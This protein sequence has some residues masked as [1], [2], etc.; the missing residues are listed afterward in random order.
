MV[1]KICRCVN[2]LFGFSMPIPERQNIG[3]ARNAESR[4]LCNF[5]HFIV[6]CIKI[7]TLDM[8][9]N[10]RLPELSQRIVISDLLT[11]FRQNLHMSVIV[12][13]IKSIL[14]QL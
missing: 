6:K 10:H 5:K 9:A 7:I 12:D 8:R 14:T 3:S 1:K 11:A 2:Y 4:V 13:N